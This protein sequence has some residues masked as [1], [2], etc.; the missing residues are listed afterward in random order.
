M[1]L[2]AGQ[3][4]L[5]ADLA[6]LLLAGDGKPLC[7]LVQG[8][9]QGPIAHDTATALTFSTEDIDTHGFH[10][11]AVNN[12]RITP[13]KAG[14]YRFT[15]ALFFPSRSD[16]TLTL[17][18]LRKNGSIQLPAGGRDSPSATSSFGQGV[19]AAT[20][21]DMNGTTDYVELMIQARNAAV[22]TYTTP[23]SGAAGVASMLD[24]EYLRA[25]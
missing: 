8:V 1:G 9:A 16:W 19:H 13:T 24:C 12:T 7:K 2:A 15:G 6:A 11:T 17:G 23:V 22:A 10:S 21:V 20:I 25:L 14:Y 4:A 3:I 18:Y 5:D